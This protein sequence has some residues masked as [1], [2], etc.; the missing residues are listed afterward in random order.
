MNQPKKNRRFFRKRTRPVIKKEIHFPVD[1][2]PRWEVNL[3]WLL[4]LMIL[5]TIFVEF[6]Y[7]DF[8]YGLW[9]LVAF[10]IIFLPVRF[11]RS[12]KTVLP[13]EFEI[14]L[15]VILSLDVVFG[16]FLN[17]YD[18]LIYYDKIIHYHD[19]I[20]IAFSGFLLIYSL[21]FTGRIKASPLLAGLVIV[22]VTVGFGGIWEIAEYASDNIFHEGAQGSPTMSA[23]DD[24]MWDLI[25]DFLGGI[26]GAVFGTLYIRY[27][28]RTQ[29]RRFYEV[30]NT[31]T[32]EQAERADG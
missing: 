20:L 25:C 4:K 21:Y 13:I 26:V 32:G 10:G 5:V 31:P 22:L 15:L 8:L 23:I 17:L 27:S 11:A 12:S 19:S 6:V 1:Y 16:R 9:G 7:G 3:A 28:H 18:T 24:T 29:R 14:I 30:V 2:A